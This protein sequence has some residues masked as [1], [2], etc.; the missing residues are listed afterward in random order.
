MINQLQVNK[1]LLLEDHPHAQEWLSNA[2]I[3]AFG[4]D[5]DI[6]V[7]ASV[8]KAKQM[9]TSNIYGLVISDLH[10]P[11]GSGIELVFSSKQIN[12]ACPC[13]IATIY[14]DDQHLFPS[15]QA[16]ADGFILKDEGIEEITDMLRGILDGKPPISAEIASRM[17]QH[18][19]KDLGHSDNP[20]VA[21]TPR[22]KE[23]L[24]YLAKGMTTKACA[25]LMG[26]GYFTASEYIKNVYRK[27]GVH[28]RAEAAMEAVRLGMA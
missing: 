5:V 9:L 25:K 11:D 3:S 26:I 13:V 12:S 1:V 19:H 4:E 14:A 16:G 15:L 21:L 8:E 27:L 28:S 10:V 24:Q 6:D 18:F 20:A 23:I 22:E 2:I 7:T 17:L